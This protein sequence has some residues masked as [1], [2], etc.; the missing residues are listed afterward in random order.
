V[1]VLFDVDFVF[2]GCRRGLLVARLSLGGSTTG[3]P[4]SNVGYAL[5]SREFSG[6][7]SAGANATSQSRPDW[8]ADWKLTM[9]IDAFEIVRRP[10]SSRAATSSTAAISGLRR[11]CP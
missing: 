10:R 11:S 3:R 7:A 2:A 4:R 6:D 5:T 9:S 1:I 8:V